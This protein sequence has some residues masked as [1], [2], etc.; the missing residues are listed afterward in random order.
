MD[1]L[2]QRIHEMLRRVG[3]ANVPPRVLGAGFVIA[4]VA[5][6]V[7]MRHWWPAS[8]VSTMAIGS[9]VAESAAV[10]AQTPAGTGDDSGG[11]EAT[12]PSAAAG[13]ISVGGA[14]GSG[15]GGSQASSVFVHVVGAVRR[16]GLYE[17]GADARIA[18]A[19]A[20]AGGLL[21]NAAE[22]ALNLAR[23]VTDGEQIVVPTQDELEAGLAP[24]AESGP[25]AAAAGA[26]GG[27]QLQIVKVN[28]NTA[29]ASL[30]DT[31][32]GV[33]PSTAQKIVAEREANGLF[34][35]VEDLGRVSGLGPKRIEA[36]K[37]LVV[38]R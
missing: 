22:R 7:A 5:I 18:D 29:D 34:A 32:P 15:G 8:D 37:D 24:A 17:V 36:L 27:A 11:G 31:L 30:L 25:S 10:G 12:D 35:S 23:L 16:P 19:V 9:D 13:G 28:V 2:R 6:V 38:V 3:L 26:V 21:G 4:L 20:A 14:D 1:A 33:G